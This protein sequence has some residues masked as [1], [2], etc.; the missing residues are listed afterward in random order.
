MSFMI[1]CSSSFK[2]DFTL[3]SF[4]DN[5]KITK[6]ELASIPIKDLSKEFTISLPNLIFKVMMYKFIVLYY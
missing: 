5:L 4:S 1:G 2:G 6:N 3:K